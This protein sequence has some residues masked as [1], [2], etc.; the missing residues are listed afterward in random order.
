MSSITQFGP[1]P[2][3]VSEVVD[4]VGGAAPDGSA[5]V[6]VGVGAVLVQR[7]EDGVVA[8][9]HV[10]QLQGRQVL[11]PAETSRFP[12]QADVQVFPLPPSFGDCRVSSS[13]SLELS[14]RGV[15]DEC[16]IYITSLDIPV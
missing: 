10:G 12:F 8:Q 15:M 13:P 14:S 6:E 4:V 2:V 9:L 1:I 5:A 7:L 16:Q 11:H 3:V